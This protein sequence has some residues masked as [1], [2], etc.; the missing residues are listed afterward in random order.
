[1]MG[2]QSTRTR[3]KAET[4]ALLRLD[5]S[6]VKE[7]SREPQS[8]AQASFFLLP[9]QRKK[10]VRRKKHEGHGKPL[11]ELSWV[12]YLLTKGSLRLSWFNSAILERIH[13]ASFFLSCSI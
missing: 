5:R 4:T 2:A 8:S 7:A 1:M 6:Q 12:D 11:M 9:F 10:G 13:V 3:Y